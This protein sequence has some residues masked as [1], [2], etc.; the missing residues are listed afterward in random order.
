MWLHDSTDRR[1]ATFILVPPPPS[2]TVGSSCV[3][4]LGVQEI[5]TPQ[6]SVP[7]ASI[8]NV[9]QHVAYRAALSLH[10]IGPF[11]KNGRVEANRSTPRPWFP[12]VQRFLFVAICIFSYSDEKRSKAEPFC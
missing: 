4:F 10:K 9:H 2:L 3:L 12:T 6:F 5:K 11:A 1:R 7:H 8:S